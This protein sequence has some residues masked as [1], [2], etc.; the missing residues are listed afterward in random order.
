MNL[1][2]D[3]LIIN[4]N[5][6]F[7]FPKY[8]KGI[9]SLK[10]EME[11]L[12]HIKNST[13]MPIPNP[14]Y[15]SLDSLEVGKAFMGYP[16]INGEPLWKESFNKIE[17]EEVLQS[18]AT[19]IASFLLELHSISKE[20]R[21]EFLYLE[22]HDPRKEIDELYYRIKSEL[23]SFIRKDAQK[24]IIHSFDTFLHNEQ[25][26][27]IKETL[28]HGDFGASN[29]LWEPKMLKIS[30]IID[31][32]SSGLG[33]P[34]YDFAGILSSYGEDF[35]SRVISLYPN[36]EEISKRVRFYKSTFALQ[37]ALHGIENNDRKAFEN[38]IKDYK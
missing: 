20:T 12:R 22:N 31:F 10:N 9:I 32:G 4:N 29:I 37:E 5:L 34:A 19:Q 2:N 8:Q 24:G 13:L 21:G 17:N 16:L 15:Q 35:F 25:S 1:D 3:V 14:V 6:V 7:R 11:I 33:D 18:L 30:G 36:G 26:L 27:N 38:G 28:I 23:F